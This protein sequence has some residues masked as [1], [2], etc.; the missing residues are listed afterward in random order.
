MIYSEWTLII[1][2]FSARYCQLI[3]YIDRVHISN[4]WILVQAVT[5][6]PVPN[7]DMP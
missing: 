2:H 5:Y 6:T 7:F 3:Y 1:D 4:F